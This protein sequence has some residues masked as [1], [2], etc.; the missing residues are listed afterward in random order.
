MVVEAEIVN[1]Y[2][3]SYDEPAIV[4]FSLLCILFLILRVSLKKSTLRIDVE[5]KLQFIKASFLNQ[6]KK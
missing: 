5:M 4:G 1:F 2:L 6:V 3:F